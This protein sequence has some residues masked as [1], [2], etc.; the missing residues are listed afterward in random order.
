MTL[1]ALNCISIAEIVVYTASLRIAI[2]LAARYGFRATAGWVYLVIFS[3]VRITGA[4]LN[5][6]TINNP[7]N[8]SL[9][10][11][12]EVMYPIGISALIF[13]LSNLLGQVIYGMRSEGITP[14]VGPQQNTTKLVVLVG[15]IVG[16]DG[17]TVPIE[18]QVGLGLMMAGLWFLMFNTSFTMLAALLVAKEKRL[19]FGIALALPFMIVRIVFAGL[20]TFGTDPRFRSYGGEGSF[21]WYFLGMGVIMEMMVVVILEGV[22]LTLKE[23]PPRRPTTV[24]VGRWIGVKY[25]GNDVTRFG[26]RQ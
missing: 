14:L 18:S 13:C 20:A 23:P 15:W 10:V 17:G 24:P 21:M 3:L 4:S 25:E 19:L 12:S 6:A 7:S 22:G 5:L 1:T 9:I 2:L 11:G 16:G 26:M 8:A